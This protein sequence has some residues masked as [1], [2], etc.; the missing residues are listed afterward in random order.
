M[1]KATI[2]DIAYLL[3]Q[4][5]DNGQPKPIFFQVPALLNQEEFRKQTK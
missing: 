4:A 3:E 5:K 1:N 2:E